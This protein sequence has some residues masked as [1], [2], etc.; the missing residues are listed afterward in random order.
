MES[1]SSPDFKCAICGHPVNLELDRNTDETGKAVHE[2]CYVSRL[3]SKRGDQTA[4]FT[5]GLDRM[6]TLPLDVRRNVKA[7]AAER[8][9]IL[10]AL[11][12]L[13]GLMTTTDGP[14][15]FQNYP[16]G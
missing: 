2:D 7:R 13:P 8:E 1:R 11:K 10:T 14:E 12:A 16:A 9:T 15:T 5:L 4:S 6:P 3:S